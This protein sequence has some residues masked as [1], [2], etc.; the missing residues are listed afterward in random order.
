MRRL[1]T[2][3]IGGI[4]NWTRLNPF[5]KREDFA[6]KEEPK[7]KPKTLEAA[8]AESSW[9][10]SMG[11]P[12]PDFL[13]SKKGMGV[14]DEMRE[15]DAL[16]S[17]IEVKKSAVLGSNWKI[18]P[19]S[20]EPEDQEIAEFVTDALDDVPGSFREKLRDMLTAVEYGFAVSNRTYKLIER[21]KH[22]GKFGIFDIKT[23]E[24]HNFRFKTDEFRN[25]TA[26]VQV[27]PNGREVE[28]DPKEF[29]IYTYRREF[30]NP[31]G[32]S[33]FGRCYRAWNFKKHIYKFW[34]IYLERSSGFIHI[35]YDEMKQNAEAHAVAKKF[36]T[37]VQARTGLLLPNTYTVTAVEQ[38]GRGHEMFQ[39][40]IDKQN[41]FMARA[42]FVPELLMGTSSSGGGAYALGQEHANTFL[43]FV[44]DIRKDLEE[45][46][47]NDQIIKPLIDLNFPNVESYPKFTFE[48]LSEDAKYEYIARI[49]S[50]IEKGVISKDLEIENRVREMLDLP[51]KEEEEEP[52]LVEPP[53]PPEEPDPDDEPAP[54]EVVKE[55]ASHAKGKFW[56]ALRPCE[57]KVNFSRIVET[58]DSLE[59]QITDIWADLFRVARNDL[60]ADVKRR[61]IITDEK[62]TEVGK[63]TLSRRQDMEKSFARF[64]LAAFYSGSLEAQ[65]EAKKASGFSAPDKFELDISDMPL[66]DMES[67]FAKKGLNMTAAIRQAAREIRRRAF[68]VT[69]IE[70]EKVLSRAKIICMNG[71]SRVDQDWTEKELKKLF[72]GY[73]KDGQ[74]TDKTLGE[75]W[76]IGTIVRNNFNTA[77]N[78]GRRR[79][80]EDP[81]VADDIV[82]YDVSAVLDDATTDYCR[83]MDEGGPYRKEDIDR[84]GWFPAHH[85]CRTI[86][87]PIL[88]GEEF[89]LHELPDGR[90][91]R[92]EGFEMCEHLHGNGW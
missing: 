2:A 86:V 24:P 23:K 48:P 56:R 7:E 32:R 31:Y 11:L 12:N 45:T 18:V 1:S 55:S 26:L 75:M 79:K 17:N 35:A 46:V 63:L 21:G 15:D 38:S 65:A 39:S 89:T 74:I 25:I 50:A 59:T 5:A 83:A 28:L 14:I 51:E 3:R 20:D 90:G 10:L 92:G 66:D 9:A 30:A 71:L 54:E 72:E 53:P 80:F 60:I 61:K 69:G 81:D 52:D 82:A 13:I 70:T 6:P 4:T 29:V 57:E 43:W 8:A 34:G 41:I 85:G 58:T 22:K 33:D 40:A 36:V 88:R 42:V 78:D 49:I 16:A 76:R 64:M 47:V 44:D 77:F 68:F 67:A 27:D 37:D 91:P 84:E 87:I 73:L 62:E 19:A